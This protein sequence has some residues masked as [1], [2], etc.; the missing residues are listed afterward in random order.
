MTAS[1]FRETFRRRL[2][3]LPA[4]L[5]GALI[6]GE[7]PP[8]PP[9]IG[10]AAMVY[11]PPASFIMGTPATFAG[12][13][14]PDEEPER[15]VTLT[16]GCW[17]ALRETTNAEYAAFLAAVRAAGTDAAWAHPDQPRNPDGSAKDHTPEGWTDPVGRR[18]ELP[19]VGVDWWDAWAYAAWAGL[20]LPTEAEWEYACRGTDGRLYAWGAA[21]PPPVGSGNFADDARAK[22]DPTG[23][24]VK[25][26]DDG[27]A[28]LAPAGACPA[29]TSWCGTRDQTGNV[30]EWC[31]DRYGPATGLP[32]T[33]PAGAATGSG[34][35][36]KGGSFRNGLAEDFR[37]AFRDNYDPGV[38]QDDLGFRCAIDALRVSWPVPAVPTTPGGATP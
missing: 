28:D 22:V 31:A 27:F 19:V 33:D 21:W 7:S 4:M 16:Q 14:D 15:R 23:D 11:L 1:P 24:L 36:V 38:R 2:P 3:V 26:Y 18:S 32:T 17:I 6:A 34:R 13:H 5:L 30:W 29:A 10:P 37:C 9:R 8:A 12:A 25:G 35:V 20:R